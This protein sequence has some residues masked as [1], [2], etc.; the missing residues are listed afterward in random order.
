MRHLRETYSRVSEA[1]EWK[2]CRHGKEPPLTESLVLLLVLLAIV[3]VLG[4]LHARYRRRAE[5]AAK[6]R[7]N[8]SLIVGRG[9]DTE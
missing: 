4:W 6:E 5:L 8:R 1:L 7:S 2:D 9:Q 3:V